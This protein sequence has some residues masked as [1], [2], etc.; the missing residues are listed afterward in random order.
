MWH[1]KTLSHFHVAQK[2]LSH[3][4]AAQKKQLH[5]FMSWIPSAGENENPAKFIESRTK[6]LREENWLLFQ[7]IN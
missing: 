2:T 6:K 7:C 4:H 3:F 1:K 5:N